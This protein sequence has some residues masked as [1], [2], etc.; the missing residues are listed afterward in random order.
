M[1]RA[2]LR[3]VGIVV[4]LVDEGEEH[5]VDAILVVLLFV[6]VV[7]VFHGLVEGLDLVVRGAADRQEGRTVPEGLA[8]AGE[9]LEVVL[10]V[11]RS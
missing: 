6:E 9:R 2:R 3:V 8:L 7:I 10:E 11:S 4:H 1:S 5:D